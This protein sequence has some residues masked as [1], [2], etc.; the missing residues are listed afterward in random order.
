MIRSY[1][2]ADRIKVSI[3]VEDVSLGIDAA[4]PCG[5]IISELVTNSLK[6]AFPGGRKGEINI[7][8]HQRDSVIELLVSDNGVGIQGDIDI[9]ASES[10]GLDLVTT[11]AEIQL[12]GT[13]ALDRDEGTMFRITFER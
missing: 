5:L 4:I 9:K 12:N 1:R 7:V 6:H 8:L 2:A 13:I 3:K 10:L 11:L